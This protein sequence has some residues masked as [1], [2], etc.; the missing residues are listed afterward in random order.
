MDWSSVHSGE[1]KRHGV[2]VSFERMKACL[3]NNSNGYGVRCD[4]LPLT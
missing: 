1:I 2:L 3:L 4:P